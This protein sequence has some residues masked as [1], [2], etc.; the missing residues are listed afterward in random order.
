VNVVQL[1]VSQGGIPKR[2]IAEANLTLAGIAG[3]S[4]AH[5]KIHGG[6]NQAVLLITQEGIEEL[7][8]Q[9]FPLYPGALGENITTQGLDRRTLRPQQ[10][11][12]I[13]NAIIELT[14][15]RTP[16]NT[17]NIYGPRIQTAI[18]D[19]QCKASNP[20][21]PLWGLSGFYAKVIESASLRAGDEISLL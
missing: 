2:A 20:A 10:R 1:S 3:D 11:Y 5:P 4:W 15:R 18:F 19:A 21:S 9:G 8:A 13:S 16:C 14:K 12:R 17:L 7:I 6:P